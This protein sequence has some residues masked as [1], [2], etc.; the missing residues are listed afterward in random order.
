[1][2]MTT[3]DDETSLVSGQETE[4]VNQDREKHQ[5]DDDHV[6]LSPVSVGPNHVELL[7]HY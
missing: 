4:D 6:S 5:Q 1:M 7:L 2:Q 3:E